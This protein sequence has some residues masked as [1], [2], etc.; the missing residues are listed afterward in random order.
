MKVARRLE[1]S[2]RWLESLEGSLPR[3]VF[4]PRS[5]GADQDFSEG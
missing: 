1:R 4:G 5:F 2:W 3:F